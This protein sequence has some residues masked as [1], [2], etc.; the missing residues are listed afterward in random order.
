MKL[1][2][3]LFLLVAGTAIPLL[4]LAAVLAY[5]LLEHENELFPTAA[6]DRNRAFM[7]AVD[8]QLPGH[9]STLE[10]LAASASLERNDLR[11]FHAEA[12]RWIRRRGKPRRGHRRPLR[13]SLAAC[14][15]QR[16]TSI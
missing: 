12:T 7:S 13:R 4:A 14:T 6:Q 9:I 16:R 2:T 1:R 5:F 8:A 3:N 15:G 11:T 10:A